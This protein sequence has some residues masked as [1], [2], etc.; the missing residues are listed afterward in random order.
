[1]DQRENGFAALQAI[2]EFITQQRLVPVTGEQKDDRLQRTTWRYLLNLVNVTVHAH[3]NPLDI[4]LSYLNSSDAVSSQHKF[5]VPLLHLLATPN[6][7]W[8]SENPWRPRVVA[9]IESYLKTELDRDW[10]LKDVS[11][12]HEKIEKYV[13]GVSDIERTM[14]GSL[15]ALT[16]LDRFNVYRQNLL[17]TLS[18]PAGRLVL[19]PFLP[20]N[21]R[22]EVNELLTGLEQFLE[23]GDQPEVVDAYQRVIDTSDHLVKL[24]EEHCTRYSCQLAAHFQNDLVRLVKKSF[25]SNKATQPA[26]V[27]IELRDKKY[28]L[29][30]S[31]RHI[32]IGF[33]VRCDGPGYAHDVEI[34]LM[35]EAG[36]TLKNDQVLIGRLAPDS[37]LTISVAA[38]VDDIVSHFEI[39]VTSGTG[40][41]FDRSQRIPEPVAL[42]AQPRV[43]LTGHP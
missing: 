36:L 14:T 39:F 17:S 41:T 19:Q 43:I 10:K 25:T 2:D 35:T 32:D 24:L 28:P 18:G 26:S 34:S 8:L 30:L 5:A 7:A 42:A 4:A 12:A 31:N 33:V 27:D 9:S 3:E 21:L 11:Q 20:T 22:A 29:H 15:S 1:M 13:R 40:E 37:A 23:V 6:M 38:V 16:S